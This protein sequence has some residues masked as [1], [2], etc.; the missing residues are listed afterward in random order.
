MTPPPGNLTNAAKNAARW[1]KDALPRIQKPLIVGAVAVGAST[2]AAIYRL[3]QN[4]QRDDAQQ[5]NTAIQSLDGVTEACTNLRRALSSSRLTVQIQSSLPQGPKLLALADSALH[6]AWDL[7]GK[8]AL[9]I[10]LQIRPHAE[11][12]SQHPETVTVQDL[13]FPQPIAYTHELFER[14]GAPTSNPDWQ[15]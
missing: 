2:S 7:S 14:Y 9:P 11:D 13:D 3:V 6:L 1:A 8:Q 12:N 15:P 10:D 4:Q 5:I